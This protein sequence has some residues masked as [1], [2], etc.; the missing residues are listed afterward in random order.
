MDDLRLGSFSFRAV[1]HWPLFRFSSLC[2]SFGSLLCALTSLFHTRHNFV[3]GLQY[4]ISLPLPL[5]PSLCIHPIC[6]PQ[7]HSHDTHTYYT[8]YTTHASIV[9]CIHTFVLSCI[10]QSQTPCHL[11]LCSILYSP[12]VP[13]VLP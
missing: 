9:F 5:P 12:L 3:L 8:V 11:D 2:R 10:T 13:I 7:S 4:P 1:G 6:T